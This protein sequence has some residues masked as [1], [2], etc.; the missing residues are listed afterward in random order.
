[1]LSQ[2]A[3]IEQS[4][5]AALRGIEGMNNDASAEL[6]RYLNHNELGL[7]LEGLLLTV[8]RE[9]LAIS[10][11]AGHDLD[12]AASLMGAPKGL[13]ALSATDLSIKLREIGL[14]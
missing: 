3:E 1:M 14:T 13:W 8:T 10:E 9:R 2:W 12:H 5:R 6:L 4:L 11:A 7:A